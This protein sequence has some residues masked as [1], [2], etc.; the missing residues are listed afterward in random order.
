MKTEKRNY[1][2][3]I[4]RCRD[5][6]YYTGFTVDDVEKRVATHNAGKGAKYTRSRLPVVL[7]WYHIWDTE[8]DARSQEYA[9]KH[10]TRKEKERL[11][12]GNR[13]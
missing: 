10:L 3:Y 2:T 11:I 13:D 1:F 9:I 4:L 5:G 12:Q 7:V 6:T 8:H